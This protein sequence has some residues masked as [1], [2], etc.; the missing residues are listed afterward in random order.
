MVSPGQKSIAL[1]ITYTSESAFDS[2]PMFDKEGGGGGGGLK[3]LLFIG[4]ELVCAM[5]AS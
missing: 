4:V 2:G 1:A 5:L 3:T